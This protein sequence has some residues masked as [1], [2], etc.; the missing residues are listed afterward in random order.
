[1]TKAEIQYLLEHRAFPDTGEHLEIIETHVSWVIL[2]DHYAFKIKKPVK[3]SFLDF[4]TLE[5]RKKYCFEEVRLNSR[6]AAS[7]YL[8]VVEIRS[9][10]NH[11]QIGGERGRIADYAVQ[12]KR[13]RT[14]ARMD[15]MLFRKKVKNEHIDRIARILI[16]FHQVTEQVHKKV[17]VN[18]WIEDFNDIE[19]V[20]P[21]L[22]DTLGSVA[23][24]LISRAIE[25]GDKFLKRHGELMQLRAETGFVRDCHGDLHTG[26]IFLLSNPIIFD[27]IEFNEDFRHIDVL[28]EIAFLSMDLERFG[29]RDLSHEFLEK[30][31]SEMNVLRNKAEG[32]LFLFYKLYRA[33]VKAKVQAI[34][35]RE[36]TNEKA[37]EKHLAA[38]NIYIHL[39][40]DYLAVL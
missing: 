11:L 31:L 35:A 32:R 27:C 30:Y 2:S 3:Y 24:N 23:S 25:C 19:N 33:N 17:D 13:L 29:R 26:N 20:R 39:M 10:G 9:D 5:L 6:L 40:S 7:I 8:G 4:S 21:F 16:D 14:N 28:D 18:K 37:R 36:T 34:K 1:M 38:A 22:Y 12:M 15:L